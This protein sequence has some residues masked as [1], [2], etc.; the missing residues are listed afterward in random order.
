MID[1]NVG[2]AGLPGAKQRLLHSTVSLYGTL[3]VRLALAFGVRVALARLILPEAH[4]LFEQA[5]RVVVI[6]SAVRDAGLTHHLM[7]DPHKSYGTVLTWSLSVGAV[8]STALILGA[9]LFAALHAELPPVLR[10]LALWI[11]I[12]AVTMVYRTFFERG[13]RFRE[14][15]GFEVLRGALL[16][17]VAIGLALAGGGIWSFV[18]GELVSAGAFA[19]LLVWRARAQIPLVVEVRRLPELLRASGYL[20]LVWVSFQVFTYIDIFIVEVFSNPEQVGYYARAYMIAVLV[21]LALNPRTLL[22]GLVEFREKPNEFA[23]TLRLGTVVYLSGIVLAA[24]FLFFNVEKAVD[25]LL[26]PNWAGA[27]P[28]LRVL[29]LVPLVDVYTTTCGETLKVQNRDRLWLGSVTLNMTALIVFGILFTREWGPV[30]MAWANYLRLGSLL[31][32]LSALRLFPGRR[33]AVLFG[34][35]QVY[36]L[37]LP[38]FVAAAAFAPDDSWTRFGLSIA[39]AG[40]GGGLLILRFLPDFRRFFASSGS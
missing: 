40:A 33:L 10:A 22:P 38:F 13:L 6:A 3:A 9:D 23:E 14:I 11:V 35:A 18:A 19:L 31:M 26:G 2:A 8:M 1:P 24:Y 4:G 25:V 21:P 7:R 28:L 30:G 12:D 37:P 20:W 16:G 34:L 39:A 29:C 27:V 15:V 17:V 36:A 5:L 32:A